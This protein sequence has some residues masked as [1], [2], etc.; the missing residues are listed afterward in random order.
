M[1]FALYTNSISPHQLPLMREVVASLGADSV[2]YAYAA[3][4]SKGRKNLG[5][6]QELESWCRKAS[7]CLTVIETCETLLVGGLR[8]ID[9]MEKRAT[10]GL[11]TLYMSERWFKPPIGMLRLL[12][13]KYFLMAWRIARLI[14]NSDSFTYLPIGIHAAR[15]MARLCGLMH[16][17]L[18][19]LFRAPKLD[20]ERKPGGRIFFSSPS[21][22]LPATPTAKS[23]LQLPTTTTTK[24]C[25]DKMRIWGYFVEPSQ[26]TN[27]QLTHPPTHNSS[28]LKVLWVGRFLKLKRVDTIIRAVGE[29]ATNSKNNIFHSPTPTRTP[30]QD[31]S[32]TPNSSNSNFQLQLDIYGTGPEEKHLKKLAAKYG[33]VIKFYPPVPIAEVRKLMREHDIYVL[34]S[35]AYEGWGAV[36]SEALEEGMKVIGT[37]EAGSSAT[38]LPKECLFHAGDWKRLLKLLQNGV[39]GVGIGEWTAADA[40]KVLKG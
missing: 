6:S 17:D 12:H 8:P 38:I 23:P 14:R 30:T 29:L 37:Y 33:D 34:S 21:L 31:N 36:V 18:R 1:K 3:A 4:E 10:V 25:L 26:L 24:Y 19:C 16:G 2:L 39:R 35:N 22:H 27:T 20:F 7:E 13:P 5:W 28:T 40:S 11:R 15:D 32:T 9:L